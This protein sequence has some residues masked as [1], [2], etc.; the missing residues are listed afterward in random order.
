MTF[1]ALLSVY[2]GDQ[3]VALA[4]C[5]ES[6]VWQTDPLD[7]VL[8]VV[9]GT[10]SPE[11]ESVLTHYSSPLAAQGFAVLRI[12]RQNGPLG[13]GLPASLN[14][15]LQALST[16]WV[17]KV[18]TDD[19]NVPTRVAETRAWAAAHPNGKL[20]GGQLQEWSEGF[21]ASGPLRRVPETPAA[22]AQRGKWRNPFNGPTVAFHRATALALGGYPVVGA[23]EDYALWGRFLQAGHAVGNSPRVWVHQQAG[24]SLIQRRGTARYRRGELQALQDLQRSGWLTSA[25]FWVHA[26][27]KAVIRSLPL[28]GI[29]YIYTY[30]RSTPPPS[31]QTPDGWERL[32]QNAH[33]WST[34][35]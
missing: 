7:A 29:Q 16:D 2:Q 34:K 12:P 27:A 35:P 13:F 24:P 32:L 1:G 5:L 19:I 28:A 30:L 9:E 3:P 33:T 23:N 4:T 25:H 22:I 17:L 8:V 21:A 10:L 26:A 6:L 11:I 31:V 15:G 18:D 14:E 20:V